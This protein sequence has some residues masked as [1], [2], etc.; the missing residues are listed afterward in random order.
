MACGNTVLYGL[1]R[2]SPTG[3]STRRLAFGDSA[4]A[5]KVKPSPLESLVWNTLSWPRMWKFLEECYRYRA[6]GC[7]AS[8]HC[9]IK[10][11][12]VK[13]HDPITASLCCDHN[14]LCLG[15]QM[16]SEGRRYR[17]NWEDPEY[18]SKGK[19]GVA[20]RATLERELNCEKRRNSVLGW[21]SCKILL[22]LEA[23]SL[24]AALSYPC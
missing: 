11:I 4:S 8:P 5:C 7:A 24:L 16:E 21:R 18:A 1:G 22:P 23:I 20:N 19:Q 10:E 15:Q 2:C 12:T 9:V 6:V 3:F 14:A 13:S 17:I